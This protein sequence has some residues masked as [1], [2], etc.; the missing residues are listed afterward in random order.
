[1]VSKQNYIPIEKLPSTQYNSNF[2]YHITNANVCKRK[3]GHKVCVL[4]ALSCRSN[5]FNECTTFPVP[6]GP[7]SKMPFHGDSRPVKYLNTV[8]NG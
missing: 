1:M 8:K 4:S 6:G 5:I 3:Y 7:K 2:W